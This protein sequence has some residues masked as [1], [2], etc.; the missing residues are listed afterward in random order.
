MTAN[1]PEVMDYGTSQVQSIVSCKSDAIIATDLPKG[2]S[3]QSQ[4]ILPVDA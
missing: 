4:C 2:V 3:A 1:I